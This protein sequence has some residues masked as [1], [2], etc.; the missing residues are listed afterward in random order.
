MKCHCMK[1]KDGHQCDMDAMPH[2]T[3]CRLHETQ[4]QKVGINTVTEWNN[5]VVQKRESMPEIKTSSKPRSSK[6]SISRKLSH[7]MPSMSESSLR[8]SS[9][10]MSDSKMSSRKASRKLSRKASH[11]SSRKAS[12]KSSR[13][14]SRKSSHKSLSRKLAAASRPKCHCPLTTGGRCPLFVKFAGERCK[15]HMDCGS[16]PM[17]P[18]RRSK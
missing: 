18:V 13:K 4:F 15:E 9:L 14:S 7:K 11:K 8:M 17:P 5:Y 3:H 2:A 16:Y 6:K 12:H 10:K 1:M